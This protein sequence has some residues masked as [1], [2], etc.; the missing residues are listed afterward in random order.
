[1]SEVES[2]FSSLQSRL[3]QAEHMTRRKVGFEG[4]SPEPA[5][6]HEN[7]DYWI[8]HN[9]TLRPV[10]GWMLSQEVVSGRCLYEAH[11]VIE[12]D[13]VLYDITL[14]EDVAC[15]LIPFCDTSARKKSF[16]K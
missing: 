5:K 4:W 2:Y 15:E 11:S 8:S 9:P 7:V 16:R 1:M 3:H 14:R 10:R 12:E 13:G 6:C